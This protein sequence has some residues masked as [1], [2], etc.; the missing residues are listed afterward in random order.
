MHRTSP[1]FARLPHLRVLALL[2]W[3]MVV[4]APVLGAGG[5]VPG[6]ARS[7][8]RTS[9]VMPMA[10]HAAHDMS[11]MTA[12]CCTGQALHGHDMGGDCP[13]AVTCA[14]VLPVLAL[15]VPAVPSMHATTVPRHGAMAPDVVRSPPLR[16][17]LLQTPRLT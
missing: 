14:S 1:Q 10:D 8:G 15:A 12:G 7:M 11:A 13:C 5:G 9:S 6:D 17:P 16:P 2:A 4:L 3:L